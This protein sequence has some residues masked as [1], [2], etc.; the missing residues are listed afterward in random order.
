MRGHIIGQFQCFENRTIIFIPTMIEKNLL[1]QKIF[2]NGKYKKFKERH[3][4]CFGR[5]Y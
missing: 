5:Y 2:S 1:L 3:K 4:L